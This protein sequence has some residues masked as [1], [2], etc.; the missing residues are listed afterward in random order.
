MCPA[1]ILYKSRCP[2]LETEEKRSESR[3]FMAQILSEVGLHFSH[4]WH[5]YLKSFHLY[6]TILTVLYDT[7]AVQL[8]HNNK[9]VNF[10]IEATI[11][12]HVTHKK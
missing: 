8:I 4:V 3:Q 2:K 6:G 9:N 1:G 7:R 5:V 12:C 11:I 10:Q